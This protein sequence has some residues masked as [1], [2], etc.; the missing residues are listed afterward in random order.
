MDK[1][2]WLCVMGHIVK[3]VVEGKVNSCDL[4]GQ[5][6]DEMIDIFLTILLRQFLAVDEG[7]A[8]PKVFVY[9]YHIRKTQ[10]VKKILQIEF[11][12]A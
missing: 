5:T 2:D 4:C 7:T 10:D 11:N 9:I 1:V 3:G 12:V 6:F 8:M